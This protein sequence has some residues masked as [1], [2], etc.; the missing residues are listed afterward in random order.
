MIQFARARA[1]SPKKYIYNISLN[2][3]G[4]MKYVKKFVRKRRK[5]EEK[6]KEFYNLNSKKRLKVYIVKAIY[7]LSCCCCLLPLSFSFFLLFCG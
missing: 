7:L 4:G 1:A 3:Y 2:A 6:I 5:K